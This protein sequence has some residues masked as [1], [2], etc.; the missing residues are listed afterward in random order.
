MVADIEELEMMDALEIYSK[1]KDSMRKRLY[2]PKKKE[3]LFSNRRW[4]NPT[5][6]RRSGPENIHL[7]TGP[8]NSRRKVKE[9]LLE[10]QKGLHLH[11]LK[12][13]IQMPV[14]R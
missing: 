7:D 2:F 1:K 13:H 14:R 11:H 12:T 6:S 3:N 5:P 4:T 9:T 10:N 8:S